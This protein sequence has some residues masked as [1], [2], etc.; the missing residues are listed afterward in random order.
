MA[1]ITEITNNITVQ[2]QKNSVTVQE[3][4]NTV[5]VIEHGTPIYATEI[6]DILELFKEAD[7]GEYWY[8]EEKIAVKGL[9]E[10]GVFGYKPLF[11]FEGD[12]QKLQITGSANIQM[13]STDSPFTVFA[14]DN[15]KVF[16]ITQDEVPVY[17]TH[18]TIKTP[19]EGGLLFY[20][21][22]LFFGA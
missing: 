3:T 8:T 17:K 2:E 10:Y 1:N 6:P 19:I 16:E 20:D 9:G 13:N 7:S 11:I 21:G 4:S 22:D 18:T 12:S 15:S 5:R 14:E